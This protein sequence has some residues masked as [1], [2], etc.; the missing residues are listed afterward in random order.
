ML[1]TATVIALSGAL[2]GC[3]YDN[4]WVGADGVAQHQIVIGQLVPWSVA[5][6]KAASVCP[7]GYDTVSKRLDTAGM[8][9]ELIVRCHE[10]P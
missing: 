2:L 3:A 8:S 6:S 9:K 7:S 10:G 5:E 1:R 4:D